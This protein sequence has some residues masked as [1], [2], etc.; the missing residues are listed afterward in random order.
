MFNRH[1]AD[2]AS[3]WKERLCI[4][5]VIWGSVIQIELNWC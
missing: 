2:G 5:M 4:D 1:F 3:L